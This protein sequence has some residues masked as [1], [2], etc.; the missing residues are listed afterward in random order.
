MGGEL[1][2]MYSLFAPPNIADN[3]PGHVQ[4]VNTP[5]KWGYGIVF[6]HDHEH[7]GDLAVRK[8]IAHVVNREAVAGNAGPRTKVAPDVVTAIAV[9]DQEDWL[10]DDMSNFETYG[11]SSTQNQKAAELLQDAGYSKSGGTWQ[12]SDG[13]AISADFV[14]PAGWTDWSTATNTVVDQL[15]SFGFDLEINSK[16]MGPFYGDYVDNNFALGAFYWMP[17]GARSSFPFFPLR[18]EM[19]CPDIDGGHEFPTGEKTIPAMDGSGEMT[20]NPLEEIKQVATMTDEDEV[21]NVI[22]RVAWHHNQTLP[23]LGVTEKQEQTWVSGQDFNTPSEDDDALGVK[24]ATQ[25]LPR[26]GK[27]TADGN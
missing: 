21:G 3:M 12:D 11:K 6:N 9:D 22:R 17:G 16:P 1:D 14:T 26:V 18:W 20:I 15:N 8:A 13:N 7:F 10:G 4:E 27:M 25:W 24:W 5:A 2:G 19:Q 23:F